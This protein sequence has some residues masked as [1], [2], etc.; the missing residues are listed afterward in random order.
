MHDLSEEEKA[1]GCSL[2]RIGKETSEQLDIIPAKIQVIRNICLK[3]ACRKCEG[4]K[5]EGL[6]VKITP[7]PA[8]IIPKSMI[9]PGLLASI[10]TTKFAD[11][12]LFYRQEKQFSRLG[13]DLG[14]AT[15]C[16]TGPL[17]RPKPASPCSIL[18]R[19]RFN[20]VP[21]IP[22]PK[23]R[24]D[25]WE[26]TQSKTARLLFFTSIPSEC[27]DPGSGSPSYAEKSL[28]TLQTKAMSKYR[29]PSS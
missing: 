6:S 14:R 1:C 22:M 26:K 12:L 18:P 19:M 27:L 4:L 9:S 13:V 16:I 5:D 11:V 23:N 29:P 20:P 10:L 7:V 17:R 3:Y 25:V 8:Q 15:M 21:Q 28:P 2:S 24:R